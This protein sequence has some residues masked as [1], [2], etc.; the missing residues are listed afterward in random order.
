MSIALVFDPIFDYIFMSIALV[1]DPIFDYIFISVA[2]VFDPIFDYIFKSI[3]LEFDPIFDYIFISIALVFDPIFACPII[4]SYLL[5]LCSIVHWCLH[6]YIGVL[7]I[8]YIHWCVESYIGVFDIIYIHIYYIY[9]IL[10]C[11]I[12]YSHGVPAISRL[13]KITGLF[14]RISSLLWVSFAKKTFSFK[15]PTN[16]S[17]PISLILLL[18]HIFCV[19][20]YVESYLLY[21]PTQICSVWHQIPRQISGF[22]LL[23][24]VLCAVIV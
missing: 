23:V 20:D 17:H 8:I 1:F 16:R 24:T 14:C 11:L 13:L 2:L 6:S 5:L 15:E 18:D 7:D 3:A 9:H 22:E 4:L 19:F 12:L 21:C 10:V